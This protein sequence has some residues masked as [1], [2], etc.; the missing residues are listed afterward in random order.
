MRTPE[1][2]LV[3]SFS[4]QSKE[5]VWHGKEVICVSR[6]DVCPIID[7]AYGRDE[8]GHPTE[9]AYNRMKLVNKVLKVVASLILHECHAAIYFAA[10]DADGTA[11]RA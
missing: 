11:V 7:V 3:S 9:S 8:N 2:K 10:E 5:T 4:I 1:S 6:V